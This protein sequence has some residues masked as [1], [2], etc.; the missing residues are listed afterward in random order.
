MKK[1]VTK[2]KECFSGISHQFVGA[3]VASAA[4]SGLALSTFAADPKVA[5]TTEMLEP[6]VDMIISNIAVVM[7]IGLTLFGI[8]AGIAIV[9]RLIR[10][11]MHG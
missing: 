10:A 2:A 1:F 7:P 11:F 4:V 9:P 5:I 8:M 6:V 3:G